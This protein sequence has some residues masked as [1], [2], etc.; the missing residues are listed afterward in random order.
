VGESATEEFFVFQYAAAR[1]NKLSPPL[2]IVHF[3]VSNQFVC[4]FVDAAVA[5]EV[6]ETPGTGAGVARVR[7][8]FGFGLRDGAGAVVQAE[9]LG[10]GDHRSVPSTS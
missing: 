4:L 2:S 1:L 9:R 3:P 10:D 5:W 6:A 8:G 7:L